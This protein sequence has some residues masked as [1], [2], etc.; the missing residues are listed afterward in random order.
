MH[1]VLSLDVYRYKTDIQPVS[2][3]YTL[4]P[5]EAQVKMGVDSKTCQETMFKA[6]CLLAVTGGCVLSYR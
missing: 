5:G 1:S 4:P 3:S 6:V 2:G